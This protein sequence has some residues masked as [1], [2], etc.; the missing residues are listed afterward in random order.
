MAGELLIACHEDGRRLVQ[1]DKTPFPLVSAKLSTTDWSLSFP[2]AK[3]SFTGRGRPPARFLWLQLPSALDGK[4][5]PA[6][7]VFQRE[8]EGRWRIENRRKTERVEG[9]LSP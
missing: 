5:M 6:G 9:Y 2:G 4:R 3:L 7:V 1:F 8:S